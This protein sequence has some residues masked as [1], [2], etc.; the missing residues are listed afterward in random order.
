MNNANARTYAYCAIWAG[1]AIAL[2][3]FLLFL[4]KTTPLDL[5]QPISALIFAQ[6]GALVGGVVGTLFSLAAVLLLIYN[7]EN[8]EQNLQEQQIE[9]RFFELLKIHIGNSNNMDIGDRVGKRN[10][11]SLI[12]EYHEASDAIQP[13][14]KKYELTEHKAINVAYLCLFYGGLGR[15]STE[16]LLKRLA[17]KHG[18]EFV[19]DIVA[20]LSASAFRPAR[21]TSLHYMPFD[22]HQVR[23]GHYFRHLF[24]SVGYINEQPTEILSYEGK[25]KYIKTLRAQFST[26]EQGLIFLNSLSDLGRAWELDERI[27]D[28]NRKLITKYNLVKNIPHGFLEGIDVRKY[29]PDVKFEG[30]ETLSIGRLGL[31]GKYT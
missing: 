15:A 16:I 25:Y 30:D 1:A 5:A 29:Y 6:Y 27:V 11:I 2:G 13:V 23:L 12:G 22:G 28:P 20:A 17:P 7:L 31:Q 19:K 26:H 4:F 21:V 14:C 10:F 18:T 8:Q 3:S 24:Q 9:S